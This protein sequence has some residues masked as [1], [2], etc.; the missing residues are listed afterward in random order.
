MLRRFFSLLLTTVYG[1]ASG[2]FGNVKCIR[3]VVSK[4]VP[5]AIAL[6]LY[7]PEC[8]IGGSLYNFRR[9]ISCLFYIGR[10]TSLYL[11]FSG[12]AHRDVMVV[13]VLPG[14]APALACGDRPR[15]RPPPLGFGW[16]L[17]KLRFIFYMGGGALSISVSPFLGALLALP[18]P[19]YLGRFNA[20]L[21]SD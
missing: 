14:S 16:C 20:S 7:K 9:L 5:I 2:A 1:V 17:D 19:G 8:A 21:C 13:F 3:R 10:S 11:L 18:R 6:L 4:L 15:Y 12:A